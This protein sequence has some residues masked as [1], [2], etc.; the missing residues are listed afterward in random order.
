MK[1]WEIFKKRQEEGKKAFFARFKEDDEDSGE[2][3]GNS[4]MANFMRSLK[5]NPTIGSETYTL[6]EP[7]EIIE[8]IK[9][10]LAEG[11]K[12]HHCFICKKVINPSY[13]LIPNK[14]RTPK[15]IGKAYFCRKHRK[16]VSDIFGFNVRY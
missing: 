13:K 5:N 15:I 1:P 3:T 9:Q 16:L 10:G 11:L 12:S 7:E 4:V 2:I 8:R 14:P 6:Y